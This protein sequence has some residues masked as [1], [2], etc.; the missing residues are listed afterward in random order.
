MKRECFCDLHLEVKIDGWI[1]G[2]KNSPQAPEEVRGLQSHTVRWYISSAYFY[3]MTVCLHKKSCIVFLCQA[4]VIS[5]CHSFTL[6]SATDHI[7]PRHTD[8]LAY[9]IH[10]HECNAATRH[11]FHTLYSEDMN[12]SFGCI[13][14][15]S[16]DGHAYYH[17]GFL[18]VFCW[19]E[20]TQPRNVYEY[21]CSVACWKDY[22]SRP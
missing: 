15:T 2:L 18:S 13:C 7:R 16:S 12:L 14:D 11:P 3:F 8:L 6:V 22:N 9:G 20:E 4:K 21:M 17:L 1:S 5:R 19:R 10:V